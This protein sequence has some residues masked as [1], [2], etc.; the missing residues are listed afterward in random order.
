MPDGIKRHIFISHYKGVRH[1]TDGS[2]DRWAIQEGVLIPKV[3]GSV[4][5]YD[6]A[7]LC[8]VAPTC[9]EKVITWFQE[10]FNAGIDWPHL[11]RNSRDIVKYNSPCH[12]HG[13]TL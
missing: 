7:N 2:N 13:V 3:L 9:T 5:N 10:T 11:I 8:S 1:E 12:V 4:E 6:Y